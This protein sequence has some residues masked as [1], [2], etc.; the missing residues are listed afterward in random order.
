MS[1]LKSKEEKQAEVKIKFL[2]PQ[3]RR[4]LAESLQI[5]NA[6]ENIKTGVG[7][8]ETIKTL[9]RRLLD[10][11]PK[12]EIEK[13]M[14]EFRINNQ[15]IK[16]YDDLQIIDDAKDQWVEKMVFEQIENE[17]RKADA[18]TDK[19]LKK[20]QMKK[21]LGTA[22]KGLDFLP[23]NKALKTKIANIESGIKD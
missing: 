9:L 13:Y 23:E 15:D 18:L 10:E 6:T 8:F 4:I 16:S 17:K 11:I 20:Q 5:I 3:V 1:W 2:V 14:A 21:V 12:G 7:R 22:L 19:K